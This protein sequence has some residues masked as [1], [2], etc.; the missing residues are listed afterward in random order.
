ME[1][2]ESYKQQDMAKKLWITRLSMWKWKNKDNIYQLSLKMLLQEGHKE[3]IE[4][5]I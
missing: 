5:D 4:S 2:I 3:V 1:L